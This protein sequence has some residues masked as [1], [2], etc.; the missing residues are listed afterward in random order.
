MTR[1]R[2][3]DCVTRRFKP[4]V[5]LRVGDGPDTGTLPAGVAGKIMGVACPYS[6][7]DFYGTMFAEGCFDRTRAEKVP[8][9]K[10]QLFRDH[11]HDSRDHVGV[12]RECPDVAGALMMHADCFDTDEGKSALDYCKSVLAA[13]G[14]TGLS[15][16]VF[17]RNA[18]WR[19]NPTKRDGG[20]SAG[21]VPAARAERAPTVAPAMPDNDYEPD[22]VYCFTEC[23]LAEIS[24]TPMP[25]VPGAEVMHARHRDSGRRE[26]LVALRLLLTAIPRPEI[27]AVAQEFGLGD[28]TH[29]DVGTTIRHAAGHTPS[30]TEIRAAASASTH[31][32]LDER[33][34][35]LRQQYARLHGV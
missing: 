22:E 32:P 35:Y 28:L 15:V 17:V 10:V 13:E 12:V 27:L 34:A 4:R 3:Y 8:Q 6:T 9:G 16:G 19:P 24:I 2:V 21:T 31:V 18:E 33:L 11:M 7:P 29:P 20:A 23:E 30:D 1:Q 14:F 25:A 5:T 26:Q